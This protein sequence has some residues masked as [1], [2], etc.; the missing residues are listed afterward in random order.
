MTR[1]A[2]DVKCIATYCL[3]IFEMESTVSICTVCECHIKWDNLS[4]F[5]FVGHNTWISTMRKHIEN[6]SPASWCIVTYPYMILPWGI[7]IG[8]YCIFGAVCEFH[9]VMSIPPGGIDW[10][11]LQARCIYLDQY[12]V[13]LLTYIAPY[14]EQWAEQYDI[15]L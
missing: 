8:K 15:A 1:C 11:A 13:Y 14:T 12:T 5:Q 10:D 9:M 6:M 2:F 4:L 7:S 3:E